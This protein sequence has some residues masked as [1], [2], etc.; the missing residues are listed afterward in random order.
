MNKSL[1]IRDADENDVALIKE[2]AYKVWPDAY[3]GILPLGQVPYM[4]DLIYSE[5][6]LKNQILHLK[7]R[8][9]IL[10]R[11]GQAVG[12]ASYSNEGG[13]VFKL[14]KLYVFTELQGKGAGGMLLNWVIKNIR[15]EHASTLILTV[16]RNNLNAKNFY[17]KRGFKVN[18]EVK[19]DIGGGYF[20][21][22]Y[23]MELK[24]D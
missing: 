10:E 23:I 24:L 19:I 15:E 22:D 17:E 11:D 12:F 8:F 16:N 6:S 21:D 2:I 9:L 20:M 3:N 14:N 18:R 7:H 5:E 1:N 4:L 13:A